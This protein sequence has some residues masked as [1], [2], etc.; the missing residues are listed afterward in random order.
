MFADARIIDGAAI[1]EFDPQDTF[2]PVVAD[3][4]EF[5]GIDFLH[6][7]DWLSGLVLKFE[8]D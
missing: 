4:P 1:V 2:L 6:F 7:H 3:G 5:S 8:L